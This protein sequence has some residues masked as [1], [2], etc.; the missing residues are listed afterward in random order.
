MAFYVGW[1]GGVKLAAMRAKLWDYTI[2]GGIE[3]SEFGKTIEGQMAGIH[4][5]IAI[6]HKRMVMRVGICNPGPNVMSTDHSPTVA[7]NVTEI[8]A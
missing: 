6:M 5:D 7:Q 3:K 8:C 1:L 2:S 4:A